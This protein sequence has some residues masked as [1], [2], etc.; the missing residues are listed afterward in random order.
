MAAAPAVDLP[1]MPYPRQVV[2]Q[3][4][5]LSI[6]Q[7]FS[8]FV[9]DNAPTA[10]HALAN[11]TM[12][13]LE[14]QTGLYL[15]QSM[16]AKSPDVATL[17]FSVDNLA[18]PGSPSLAMDESYRLS[19]DAKQIRIQS[20]QLEGAMRAVE[21][22]LQL[23]RDGQ[24]PAV[25]VED[26]PRFPWRGASVDSSRHYLSVDTL[27]RQIDAMAAAKLNVFHWHLW[28]DQAIRIE[29]DAYP[30]LH[31]QTS[32][33]QYYSKAEIRDIVAH[34]RARGIRVVPEI[35]MP[36]HSSAVAYT[37]P[38]LMSGPGPYPRQR[39]WGVFPP[40][41]DPSNEQLY[42]FLD[43][44]LREVAELFPD[45]YVHIGGDEPDYSEWKTN[46]RIQAFMKA[47]D[48]AN[49]PAL[50]AFFNARVEKILHKYGK[51]AM[52]WD[53]VLDP[54]L[55][56]S[57]VIQSWRGQD[58]LA[59]A[60]RQGYR[61]VL[62]TGYYLDQPQPSSYHYRNDP[63]PAALSVDDRLA[64]GDRFETY[65]WE[66]P[67]GKGGPR[68]GTLTLIQS[69]DGSVRGFTDYAGKSRAEVTVVAY[70]QGRRIKAHFDN[71]MSYVEFNLDIEDGRL[72]PSSYQLVGNV[73]WPTSG[74]LSAASS[75]SGSGIPTP[76]DGYPLALNEQEQKLILGGEAA[77]WGENYNDE[78]FEHRIWPRSF[79]V[80]ERLWSPASLT[81]EDSMYRRMASVDV[82]SQLSVGL[83]HSFQRDRILKRLAGSGDIDSLIGLSRLLEPAQYYARNWAKFNR[84]DFYH[85]L[86]N[87]NRYVDALPVES[88]PVRQM[89]LLARDAL[90]GDTA[91]QAEL[92]Q[93]LLQARETCEEALPL[94]ESRPP[95]ADVVPYARASLEL[96]NHSLRLLDELS[97]GRALA[98][99][100]R[101]AMADAVLRHTKHTPT[102]EYV[103]AL[104]RPLQILLGS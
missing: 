47:N 91:R 22:L 65:S 62:S 31:Q 85:Q 7:D 26:A 30:K 96:V 24:I 20:R 80:A 18:E 55:P 67:R 45:E 71:F 103:V 95:L 79:V 99:S 15:R 8:I 32:D 78:T 84:G 101:A 74:T 44:V 33:G 38:E 70:E 48:I 19:V 35:S 53:E 75:I 60:A 90:A 4:G 13:R 73:R 68:T 97:E 21:T 10:L 50:Q 3:Q 28:D 42:V 51:K 83:Q 43:K 2:L 86:E 64:E 41:M 77:I 87:L 72:L 16:W 9:P 89:E 49:P 98:G 94:L 17:V 66:K 59:Q 82:W 1:L 52:G 69:R 25:G 100:E 29:I 57:I 39:H 23:E 61:G 56:K 12:N 104:V 6:T 5:G 27:K 37:Y 11:R 102:T 58:S 76:P 93:Q 46:E 14:R 36:G 54:N 63:I 81:D 88:L 92:R 40:L 34:A